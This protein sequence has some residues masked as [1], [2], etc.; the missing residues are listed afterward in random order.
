MDIHFPMPAA[1]DRLHVQLRRAVRQPDAVELLQLTLTARGTPKSE[2]DKDILA[3]F[4][5]GREWVVRSFTDVTTEK[6]HE[7]WGRTR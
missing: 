1:K 7:R 5:L 6:M 3:W 4:D 2:S